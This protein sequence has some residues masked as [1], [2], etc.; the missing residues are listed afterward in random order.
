MTSKPDWS[1][2]DF[3]HPTISN[4][5]VETILNC[6]L[7]YKFTCDD[8]L[9]T[10][11]ARALELGRTFDLLCETGE[12]PDDLKLLNEK[13]VSIIR[14]RYQEYRGLM[15]VGKRQFSFQKMVDY[16]DWSLIGFI[17]L[18]PDEFPNAPIIEIKFSEEKWTQKKASYKG[19][20][21]AIYAWALEHDWVQFH[22]MNFK[23]SG[24]Q[25]FDMN[26]GEIEIDQM[27]ENVVRAIRKIEDGIREPEENKLCGWCDYQVHCPLFNTKISS[28]NEVEKWI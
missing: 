8:K 16:K 12:I 18:V 23:E 13:D 1:Q 28:D 7:K 22:V 19:M 4:F 3:S 20:Q 26:I 6:S 2:F 24:L 21:A 9:P 5:K 10:A 17:D 15:P 11:P 27:L 14:E 25:T